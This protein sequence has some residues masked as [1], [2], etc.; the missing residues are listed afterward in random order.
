M[1]KESFS[2]F[3]KKP[4]PTHPGIL[5]SKQ[6]QKGA[7]ENLHPTPQLAE[8]VGYGKIL[9][10]MLRKR[11]TTIPPVP[12]PV[13]K[14]HID[15]RQSAFTLTWFGHSSY[16]IQVNNLNILVDPV[17][18]KRASFTNG[19]GPAA[20]PGTRAYSVHDLPPI[21][22]V[23][24]THDHYDHLEYETVQQLKHKVEHW[25][26][27]LGVGSH[28]EFWGIS[29]KRTTE[30]DWWQ[31]VSPAPEITLTAT[32]ARHFSGRGFV[33]NKTLWSS[34]V[35]KTSSQNIYIGGD[36]GYDTHFAEIGERFGPFDL[37]IL[38]CGQYDLF[39]PYIHMQPEQTAQ[40]AK[41]LKAAV[42]LP[43]HWGK[44]SL[45]AHDWDDPIKRVT[46]AA[47]ELQQPYAMP[48]IGQKFILQNPLPTQPWWLTMAAGTPLPDDVQKELQH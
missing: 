29:P 13:V 36:S 2:V 22:I 30:L 26:T 14:R 33:R 3:G 45:S 47:K 10:H 44:F 48:M 20:F 27:S 6:F 5:H 18:G 43:V 37:A 11:K 1:F 7:F 19:I 12:M 41:D 42:L 25:Y 46:A 28:L 34:F 39:W 32:P 17:F 16:L 38:E 8:G 40:A 21:D 9:R 31:Q 15:E 35:L 4:A 23:I 24:I